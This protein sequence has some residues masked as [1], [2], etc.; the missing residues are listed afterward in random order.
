M[1]FV[2]CH[3]DKIFKL[4]TEKHFKIVSSLQAGEQ[5]MKVGGGF[6]YETFVHN[7]FS[8]T[9]AKHFARHGD[10]GCFLYTGINDDV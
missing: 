4:S 7:Q 3:T 1:A 2:T 8:P 6:A 5:D 9:P 10:E